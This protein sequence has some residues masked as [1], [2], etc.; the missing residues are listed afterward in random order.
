MTSALILAAKIAPQRSTQY[1]ALAS[2]LAAPELRLSPLAPAIATLRPETI[3]GRPYLLLELRTELTA[4]QVRALGEMGATSEFFWYHETI[5]GVPGPFLQPIDGTSPAQ[6]PAELVEARRYRGKTN[7]LFSQ[8]LINVARWAHPGT[9]SRLL[10]PLM[11]GGTFLFI[12]LR[13]GLDAIGI[14]RERGAVEGADTFL[15]QFLREARIGFR[16]REERTKAGR[17]MLFSINPADAPRPLSVALVHGDTTDAQVLLT[18]LPGGARA[19]LIVADL[20]YGIQHPGQ[21]QRLLSEALPAWRQV[22]AA[23]AVLALAWDA[24]RLERETMAGWVENG[25]HWVALRGGAWEALA[26]PV[27]RVIKRRDVLV[28][29]AA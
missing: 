13:V 26:H 14:E 28:A 29:R 6:L 1:A 25:G 4:A 3:A 17:R 16:R 8:V 24:T 22:A 11:G 2:A 15:A 10:D 23:D 7:E 5:G 20:P 21:L 27:D 9:P 19:D 18:G 12:A